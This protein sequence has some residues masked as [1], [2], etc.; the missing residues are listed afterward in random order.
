MSWFLDTGYIGLS[1]GDNLAT[2]H[3]DCIPTYLLPTVKKTKPTLFYNPLIGNFECDEEILLT[4]CVLLEPGHVVKFT[5]KFHVSTVKSNRFPIF[6]SYEWMKKNSIFPFY[7]A[8][9]R[10]EKLEKESATEREG[11]DRF[12]TFAFQCHP[13]QHDNTA[14]TSDSRKMVDTVDTSHTGIAIKQE[15][16]KVEVD[17]IWKEVSEAS[18][19]EKAIALKAVLEHD[20]LSKVEIS[21]DFPLTDETALI[22]LRF[23]KLFRLTVGDEPMKVTPSSV[24]PYSCGQGGVRNQWEDIQF[25][26]LYTKRPIS[27]ELDEYKG[28]S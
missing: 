9:Q 24:F 18:A 25:L 10:D 4:Y 26:R 15:E 8:L 5:E 20:L 2:I 22:L 17:R 21:P 27:F 16:N 14:I 3:K 11:G 23:A 13:Q 1:K 12:P 19:M 7:T 28:S 6:F